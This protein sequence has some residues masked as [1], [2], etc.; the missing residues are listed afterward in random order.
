MCLSSILKYS[1][2]TLKRIKNLIRGRDAYIV[3]GVPHRD[4]LHVA[5]VLDVPILGC[6]PEVRTAGHICMVEGKK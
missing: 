5:D 1:G 6:E 4:D 3:T 2:Q